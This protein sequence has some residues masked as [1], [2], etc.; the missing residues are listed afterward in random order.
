MTPWYERIIAAHVAV[1][2]AVSHG[3]RL[4]SDRYFVW[5]E[6]GRD[7]MA[8]DGGHA[9]TSMTGSTDLWTKVEFDPWAEAFEASLDAQPGIAWRRSWTAYDKDTGFWHYEWKWAV[10]GS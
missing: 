6:E 10:Y 3:A 7:D 4:K 2:D 5:Q 8:A 9:E 1:T